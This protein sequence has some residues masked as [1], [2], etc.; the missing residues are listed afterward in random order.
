MMNWRTSPEFRRNLLLIQPVLSIFSAY[1][2]GM[3][4][5]LGWWENL[6][7]VISSQ[8]VLTSLARAIY[9]F[10]EYHRGRF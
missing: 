9:N 6:I 10:I 1:L 4:Q 8:L 2:V 3:I 7:S 5:P